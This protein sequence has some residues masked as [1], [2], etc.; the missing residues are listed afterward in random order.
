MPL[1]DVEIPI[2][3][4]PLPGDVAAFL[5]E[6]DRR[7][8]QF[9]EHGAVRVTGFV[10]S[11]FETV[12]RALRA[13]S[14][15]NLAPGVAMC[16]W[17]SGLGIVAALASTL[18]FD[19]CGIEIE[20][21]LHDA[22]QKLADDY[23]LPVELIHGSFIP[24]DAQSFAE[25][26]YADQ[27]GEFCWLVTDADDAYTELG[28]EPDDFDLVFAYPWPGEESLIANLFERCAST[29]ALLLTFNQFGTVRLQ[30][31]LAD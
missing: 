13:I 29:E 1:V 2:G 8:Q 28:L 18:D 16:E 31:K 10:P 9:V 17:G 6:A 20:K 15:A 24:A 12:Y 5:L 7:V 27:S 21:E 4:A 23:E 3:D 19:A 25:Q 30:R 11:E 26:A 14:E 22:A